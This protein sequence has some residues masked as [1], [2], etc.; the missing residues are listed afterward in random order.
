NPIEITAIVNL[1][2]VPIIEEVNQVGKGFLTKWIDESIDRVGPDIRESYFCGFLKIRAESVHP[3]R[4]DS[5]GRV[6][7]REEPCQ[8]EIPGVVRSLLPRET[9]DDVPI[10]ID[11]IL[12]APLQRLYTRQGSGS[13]PHQTQNICTQILNAGLYIVDAG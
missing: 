3:E 2:P 8:F 11:V 9:E 4:A 12:L 7:M 10:R 1:L 5:T 13:L 6:H